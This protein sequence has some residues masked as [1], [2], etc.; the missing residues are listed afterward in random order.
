MLPFL[1]GYLILKKSPNLVTLKVMEVSLFRVM[2]RHSFVQCKHALFEL[3]VISSSCLEPMDCLPLGV[4]G[5]VDD[6]KVPNRIKLFEFE[7]ARKPENLTPASN[8]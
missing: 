2:Q 5:G 7:W 1:W 3:S 8:K 6:D 4:S